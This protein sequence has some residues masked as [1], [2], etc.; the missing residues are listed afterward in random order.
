[1]FTTYKNRDPIIIT[2]QMYKYHLFIIFY[3]TLLSDRISCG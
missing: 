3:K 1:M 2:F